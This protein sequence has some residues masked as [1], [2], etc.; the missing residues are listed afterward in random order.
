M[1]VI[2]PSESTS[3]LSKSKEGEEM[4]IN[5]PGVDAKMGLSLYGNEMDIYLEVLRSYLSYT[6]EVLETIRNV[7]EET[8][9]EYI[10][11]VH[12][13]K[14][15]SANI[16]AEKTRE[17]ALNLEKMAKAGDLRGVLEI[18]DSFIKDTENMLLGIK[19]WL[20]QHGGS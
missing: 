9:P 6:P 2:K 8:L 19:T 10:I 15:T 18:N 3:I 14:G 1:A 4:K 17:A 11:T 13:I 7:S 20:E 16:G 12:G 5:I